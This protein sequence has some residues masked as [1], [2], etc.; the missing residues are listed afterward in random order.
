MAHRPDRKREAGL[1]HTSGALVRDRRPDDKQRV[2]RQPEDRMSEKAESLLGRLNL[3]GIISEKMHDA[4]VRYAAVAG[5][6]RAVIEASRG[7]GGSGLGLNCGAACS[8]KDCACARHKDQYERARAA[9][10]SAGARVA[11]A[12]EGVALHGAINLDD[13]PHLCLGLGFLVAH[14]GIGVPATPQASPSPD[15]MVLMN[16][17]LKV[18]YSRA[19]LMWKAHQVLR[20]PLSEVD[21]IAEKARALFEVVPFASSNF[22]D[23]AV[24][25]LV[26]RTIDICEVVAALS[27]RIDLTFSLV[28]LVHAVE[29]R[30][31][32]FDEPLLRLFPKKPNADHRETFEVRRLQSIAANAYRILRRC[33]LTAAAA[34]T[35]V[36]K[37]IN[38]GKYLPRLKSKSPDSQRRTLDKWIAGRRAGDLPIWPMDPV[39]H[40]REGWELQAESPAEAQQS[41]LRELKSRLGELAGTK[42]PT[43]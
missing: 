35:A 41:V 26:K 24:P 17:V 15:D 33:G 39:E 9:L 28:A 43:S 42:P 30:E 23:E 32:G 31:R 2:S 4:G 27:G 22:S 14:F 6:Y 20:I 38:D 13:V 40:F 37:V 10:V 16:N 11:Q 25:G 29:E 19:M 18:D 5:A 3:N 36:M 8:P 7:T 21:A 12:V 34:A 1:R